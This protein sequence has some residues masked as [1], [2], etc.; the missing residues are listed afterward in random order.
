MTQR[1]EITILAI[2]ALIGL[3]LYTLLC[4]LTG[5]MPPCIFHSLTHLNCPGCGSQRALRALLH[6]H[7]MQ[8]WQYNI[9]LPF[10][11]LYLLAILLIPRTTRLHQTITSPRATL[12]LF[13]TVVAWWIVRNILNI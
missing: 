7:P 4:H 10:L 9:L 5:K 8:A 13:I 6:G 1:R 11:I 12:L 3:P 2:V